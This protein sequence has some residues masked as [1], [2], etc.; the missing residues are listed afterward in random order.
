[1][2][3]KD[4]DMSTTATKPFLIAKDETGQVRLTL[5]EVRRNS[6]DYP[7]VFSTLIERAF[8]TTGAARAYAVEHHGAKPGEF[9]NK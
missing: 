8:D 2:R 6:Q 4:T 3:F 5:R 1:M 7:W 9:S